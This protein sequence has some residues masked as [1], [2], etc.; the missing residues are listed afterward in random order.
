MLSYVIVQL[1]SNRA[2]AAAA[3]AATLFSKTGICSVDALVRY[4]EHLNNNNINRKKTKSNEKQ[5]QK[6]IKTF[7]KCQ[8]QSDMR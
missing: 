5:A 8:H 6:H 2:V 3:A 4:R 7:W 1:H